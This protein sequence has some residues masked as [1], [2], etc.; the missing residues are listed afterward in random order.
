MHVIVKC[1]I[2]CPLG[3]KCNLDNIVYQAN[4]SAKEN[5]HNNNVYIGMASL[6]WTFRYYNHLQSFRNP[7]LRN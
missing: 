2:E 1:K 3:N 5:D 6:N 7:T 4:I